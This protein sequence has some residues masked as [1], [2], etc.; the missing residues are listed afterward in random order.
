MSVCQKICRP[1]LGRQ[2]LRKCC[3]NIAI[4][5]TPKKKKSL[6]THP[7]EFLACFQ[8]IAPELYTRIGRI[9]F[10]RTMRGW[11]H[12]IAASA[13]INVSSFLSA[14][15]NGNVLFLRSSFFRYFF[16]F[17]FRSNQTLKF[18]FRTKL[19]LCK[20][21]NAETGSIP[22]ALKFPN[23]AVWQVNSFTFLT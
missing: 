7:R 2:N 10:R 15:C 21:T 9:D 19:F 8:N 4:M 13:N 3:V 22:I 20:G 11:T 17:L 6:E 23:E 14:F 5:S 18:K 1:T 16:C 12:F